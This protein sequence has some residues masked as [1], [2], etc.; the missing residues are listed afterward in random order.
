M[1]DDTLV[2][3]AYPHDHYGVANT[4]AAYVFTRDTAGDLTSGWT[5]VGCPDNC[6][7]GEITP[8][9]VSLGKGFKR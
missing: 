6:E 8:W 9:D 1:K 7:V 2:V 5:Q 4:G 3:G